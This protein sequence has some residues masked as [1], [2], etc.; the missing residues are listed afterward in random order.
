MAT[1]EK[2][3][4]QLDGRPLYA[5]KWCESEYERLK[6]KVRNQMPQVLRGREAPVSQPCFARMQPKRFAVGMQEGHGPGRPCLPRLPI[7]HLII[8]L[9]MSG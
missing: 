3:D 8:R 5:Y 6:D 1:A 2:Q 9:C 4:R 7:P